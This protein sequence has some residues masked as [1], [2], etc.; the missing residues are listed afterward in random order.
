MAHTS[1]DS[2]KST[3]K[4]KY[5]VRETFTK[6]RKVGRHL[7]IFSQYKL[8]EAI[9]ISEKEEEVGR[10]RV[11][12]FLARGRK[13]KKGKTSRRE[14]RED[15]QKGRKARQAE[16]RENKQKGRKRRQ[17]EEREQRKRP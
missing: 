8:S 16:G 4:R 1:E 12:V 6:C 13:R 11:F 14:E 5:T 2:C 15:K 17:A 7:F 3:A 10:K 9:Q